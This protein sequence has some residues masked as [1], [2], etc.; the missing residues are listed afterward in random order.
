MEESINF[1]RLYGVILYEVKE[2][3]RIV[4]SPVRCLEQG[5]L[6]KTMFAVMTKCFFINEKFLV[7]LIPIHCLNYKKLFNYFTMA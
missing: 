7:K 6:D 3:K 5:E 1:L 2:V 4:F